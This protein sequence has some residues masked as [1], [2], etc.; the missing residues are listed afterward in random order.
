MKPKKL[1][2]EKLFIQIQSKVYKKKYLIISFILL[3]LLLIMFFGFFK[4]VFFILLLLLLNI[5]VSY[6]SKYI[7]RAH[8]SIELIMFG[9][10]LV[11][12]SYGSKIGAVFGVISA[13][14]YYYAA[15]RF[16]YYVAIFMPLYA[17]V[18]I[19]SSIFSNVNILT[20]GLV[21]TISYTIISSIIVIFMFNAK[22]DKAIL[23]GLVNTF[24]NFIMFKYVANIFLALM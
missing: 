3:L 4:M 10:V 13:L 17:L 24:F 6:L 8:T 16:S 14:L 20:L 11:G 21:C 1:D 9:T 7:P 15:G 12:V 19:F 2:W 23:F 18:G 5:L 22:F